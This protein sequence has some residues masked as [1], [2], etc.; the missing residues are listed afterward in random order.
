MSDELKVVALTEIEGALGEMKSAINKDIVDLKEQMEADKTA[1]KLALDERADDAEKYKEAIDDI[2]KKNEKLAEQVEELKAQESYGQTGADLKALVEPLAKGAFF[3]QNANADADDRLVAPGKLSVKHLVAGVVDEAGRDETFQHEAVKELQALNDACVWMDQIMKRGEERES[4]LS[5]GGIRGTRLFKRF[6]AQAEY[7][8][9]ATSQVIDTT[10]LANWVPTAFSPLTWEAIRIGL[11]E[12]NVFDE[13]TMTAGTVQLHNE[14]SDDEADAVAEVTSVAGMS[15]FADTAVQDLEPGKVTFSATKLRS[16][17]VYSVESVE[18][19]IVPLLPRLQKKLVRNMR[20]ALA[21]GIINGMETAKSDTGGTH[22]GKLN[23]TFAATDVRKFMDGLRY[24]GFAPAT[25][26]TSD[27]GNADLSISLMRAARKLMGEKGQ[28]LANLVWFVNIAGYMDLLNDAAI[29][30]ADVWGGPATN[31]TGSVG[32]VDGVD[33]MQS[34]R[35]PVNSNATGIMDGTITDRGINIL[36]HTGAYLLGN[37]RRMTLGQ[38]AYGATDSRDLFLF[39]RG[40]FQKMYPS[41][42]WT[43]TV[44]INTDV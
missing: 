38:D 14:T 15:P 23:S 2:L 11:P 30:T 44:L 36:V 12:V 20:E 4:Y 31:R 35:L 29:K 24:F 26:H 5:S 34:R 18:E 40:D 7:I 1:T 41:T 21:D 25:D 19:S 22:Y 16:R 27:A 39:W 8:S 33:I 32:M 28:D 10:D 17:F 13:F 9:K 3:E 43:E 6:Q 42:E 37:R